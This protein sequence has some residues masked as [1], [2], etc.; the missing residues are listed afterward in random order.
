MKRLAEDELVV[1]VELVVE[2]VVV[3][4]E[5]QLAAVLVDVEDPRIAVRV[6]VYDS[7]PEPPRVEYSPR[8]IESASYT[9]L[10]RRTK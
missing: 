9:R 2:V 4:V 8:C 3:R 1:G 10:G 7:P 6:G 5:P